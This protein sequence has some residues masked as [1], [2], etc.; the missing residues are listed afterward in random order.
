MWC[1][2]NADSL[3][4]E[5]LSFQIK[6]VISAHRVPHKLLWISL[7]WLSH[8]V[9]VW[10]V[11]TGI[12]LTNLHFFFW[13]IFTELHQSQ[14]CSLILTS[15][16]LDFVRLKWNCRKLFVKKLQRLNMAIQDLESWIRHLI[17]YLHKPQ[18]L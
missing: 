9:F 2:D 6:S 11:V 8:Q 3:V 5:E 10:Q 7:L 18:K 14:T 1:T 17:I 12:C 16:S 4:S 15:W 13:E